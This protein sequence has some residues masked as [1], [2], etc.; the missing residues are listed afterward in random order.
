M[1][2]IDA[3]G[4]HASFPACLINANYFRLMTAYQDTQLLQICKQNWRVI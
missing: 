1:V 2:K 3:V 4:L